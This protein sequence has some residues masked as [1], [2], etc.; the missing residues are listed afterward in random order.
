MPRNTATVAHN[1][2]KHGSNTGIALRFIPLLSKRR[3]RFALLATFIPAI[4]LV[5]Y[6]LSS[7]SNDV[8]ARA[9]APSTD[10]FLI[11]MD[12]PAPSFPPL[13]ESLLNCRPEG[14]STNGSE[15]WKEQPTCSYYRP[16]QF[17]EEGM[18]GFPHRRLLN[19]S[20][21]WD[22]IPYW[23][24]VSWGLR[25]KV[26]G[27]G[28]ASI[29]YLNVPKSGSTTLTEALKQFAVKSH[30][31]FYTGGGCCHGRPAL[32]DQ[33]ISKSAEMEAELAKTL[34][35][36]NSN[37]DRETIRKLDQHLHP[38]QH[39]LFTIL[40]DPVSRFVSSTR[41]V[42]SLRHSA[43]KTVGVKFQQTCGCEWHRTG[44][45]SAHGGP[46]GKRRSDLAP[47][48]ERKGAIDLQGKHFQRRR[49]RGKLDPAP[50][51]ERRGRT[52][53][54]QLLQQRQKRGKLPHRA[55]T[56]VGVE[57]SVT[58][59]AANIFRCTLSFLEE[60]GPDIDIHFQPSATRIHGQYL[61]GINVSVAVFRMD[62]LSEILNAFGFDPGRKEQ[63]L[64]KGKVSV[65]RDMTKIE[66]TVFGGLSVHD[67]DDSMIQRVCNL[68]RVDV[69]LHHYLGFGVPFCDKL[70]GSS[71]VPV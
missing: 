53:L 22:V 61:Q 21:E 26:G 2:Q 35:F 19:S 25:E 32:L 27:N 8:Y 42:L 47:H 58:P 13:P 52:N 28:T 38:S 9:I 18:P 30:G 4:T 12:N 33:K 60:H 17:F 66:Q 34:R 56:S 3:R 57:E 23:E 37:Q 14:T 41:H 39:F 49:E 31:R 64:G 63:A 5:S 36:I 44:T 1:G 51:M 48:K 15:V 6:Y 71:A 65:W 20:A 43:R 46:R 59:S 10:Q 55:L 54:K 16:L 69:K 29:M 40:R 70:K 67:L 11:S 62:I 68:Y 45:S 50:G 7:L 24:Q